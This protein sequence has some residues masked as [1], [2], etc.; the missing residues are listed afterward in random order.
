MGK[1]LEFTSLAVMSQPCAYNSGNY[2][3]YPPNQ[4]C[5]PGTGY[6]QFQHVYPPAP[7]P[8]I[9]FVFKCKNINLRF[10]SRRHLARVFFLILKECSKK[11][12][13]V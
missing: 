2:P 6:P 3:G 8:G 1:F 12:N 11:V 9:I 5:P 4:E 7:P 10:A 13:S